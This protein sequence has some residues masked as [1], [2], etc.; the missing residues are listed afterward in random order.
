MLYD[1]YQALLRGYYLK[2]AKH[3]IVIPTKYF[4][5]NMDK[6]LVWDEIV[7]RTTNLDEL[8]R[9]KLGLEV[10]LDTLKEFEQKRDTLI[11]K[12]KK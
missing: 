5:A 2:H 11:L 8:E 4:F 10:N 1:Y 12:L 3:K 6:P 7:E 9:I